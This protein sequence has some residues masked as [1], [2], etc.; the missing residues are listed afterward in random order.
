M[1]LKRTICASKIE[2]SHNE[3][4]CWLFKISS[5]VIY[6]Y[7]TERM[8]MRKLPFG[9]SMKINVIFKV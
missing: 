9:I 1:L 3:M 8:R 2:P 7:I 6:I 4:A 5:V